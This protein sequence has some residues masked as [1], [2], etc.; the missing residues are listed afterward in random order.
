MHILT[1]FLLNVVTGSFSQI[2][3][4]KTG[5]PMTDLNSEPSEVTTVTTISSTVKPTTAVESQSNGI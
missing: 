1:A 3:D 4:H 2:L 5:A